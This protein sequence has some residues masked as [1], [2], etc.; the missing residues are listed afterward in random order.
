MVDVFEEASDEGWEGSQLG[1]TFHVQ[2]V[3]VGIVPKA[4]RCW[5]SSMWGASQPVPLWDA[6]AEMKEWNGE[7]CGERGLADVDRKWDR[8][9][10]R[11]PKRSNVVGIQK[12]TAS[13]SWP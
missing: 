4:E 6:L 2:T 9:K 10:S 12:S 8:V 3:V 13:K 5:M 1:A 11:K 7:A